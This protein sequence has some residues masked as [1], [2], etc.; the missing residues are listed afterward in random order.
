MADGGRFKQLFSFT[1]TASAILRDN[2]HS[3][4]ELFLSV[5]NGDQQQRGRQAFQSLVLPM[6]TRNGR[7]SES[8]KEVYRRL[9]EE[10]LDRSDAEHHLAELK[11]LSQL[12]EADAIQVLRETSP[13]KLRKSSELLLAL[14][15]ALGSDAE[16]IREAFRVAAAAGIPESDFSALQQQLSSE[17]D[18]KN[19]LIRSGRGVLAALVII[20]IFILTAKFLQSVIFGLILAFIMLP[21]EKLFERALGNRRNPLNWLLFLLGLPLRP[22]R[23][24]SHAI[25]RRGNDP[26]E[27]E[28]M[29]KQRKQQIIRQSVT[30]TFILTMLIAAGAIWGMTKLTGRYMKNLQQ[31][32]R[33]LGPDGQAVSTPHS[34]VLARTNYY[35]D[36]LRRR[37]EAWPPAQAGIGFL[38]D[39]INN[40]K[41]QAQSLETALAHS[42][43]IFSFTKGIV[44]RVL[45]L[46]GDLL[47][48]VFFALLFLLKIASFGKNDDNAKNRSESLVRIFFNGT[49]LPSADENVIAD[50]GRIIDGV[51]FR[52]K[53]WLKGYLTLILVDSTVYTTCFFFLGVPYYLPLGI[54]AG[55]GIVLPYLGPVISCATTLLVTLAVGGASGNLLLAIVICYL[56]YNGI[57]EQFIFY[58]AVI[59][60]SLGLSTLET[61]IMILLGAIFA[62]I[63]GMIFALPA[64][65]VAK[66]IIPQIYR[67]LTERK[68]QS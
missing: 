6:L 41:V 11:N 51:Q 57:V 28:D 67:G 61:I 36:G 19:R 8:R 17:Y 3:A 31:N 54:L 52:L 43:G 29:E 37:L 24:L 39:L 26:V 35:L 48:T 25:T 22:L 18:R 59:G 62:G 56:I 7:L 23:S 53:V 38:S 63:P 34:S 14:A 16:N 42:G 21:A 30:L 60:D 44:G 32:V 27:P 4:G 64:A 68:A 1:R 13:E 9:L 55:C 20:V 5:K 66:Y 65:S 33:V 49:W 47:L 10:Q 12:P 58:P 46:I 40:P 45:S 15:V 2:L 50:A